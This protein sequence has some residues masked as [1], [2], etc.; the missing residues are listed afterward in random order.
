VGGVSI[1]FEQL[2]FHFQVGVGSG[3][4]VV[5]LQG[6]GEAFLGVGRKG[7]GG[8]EAIGLGLFRVGGLVLVHF[9]K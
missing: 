5:V 9:D 4:C 1:L 7:E 2:N 8:D 6:V 3:V